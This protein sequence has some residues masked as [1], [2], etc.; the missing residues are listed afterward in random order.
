MS[1]TDN[2]EA[3]NEQNDLIERC[4]IA[5]IDSEHLRE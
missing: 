3:I 2:L 4:L 1:K 5:D